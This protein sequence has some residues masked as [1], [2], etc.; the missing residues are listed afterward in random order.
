MEEETATDHGETT[1]V[2]E[3]VIVGNI[4]EGGQKMDE[5]YA[6]SVIDQVTTRLLATHR[7][8]ET[9]QGVAK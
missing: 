2:E 1:G 7:T 8:R 5:S 4:E 3:E 9:V 6:T